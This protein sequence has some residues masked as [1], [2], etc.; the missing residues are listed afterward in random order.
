MAN[1]LRLVLVVAGGEVGF[2]GVVAAAQ[3]FVEF[4]L[5]AAEGR[6]CWGGVDDDDGRLGAFGNVDGT[7]EADDAVFVDAVKTASLPLP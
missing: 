2:A 7:G 3:D 4:G 5:I 1:G 6:L